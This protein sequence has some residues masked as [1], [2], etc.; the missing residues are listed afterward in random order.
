MK[1]YDT[2]TKEKKDLTPINGKRINLFVCG[3][4]VYD[5]SHIGHAR[6]YI[7]FD[8]LSEYL[9]YKGYVVFYLQNITDIDDKIIKRANESGTVASEI[10]RFYYRAYIEDMLRLRVNGVNFYAPATFYIKEIIDQVKRLID[11]GYAY[12]TEDG[13][14]FDISKFPEYGKLSHQSLETI[15]AG[16]RIEINEK[17]KN[18]ADF[19]LWKKKKPGEPYWDS[20][21]G[22]GRPGWHIEDT[23][24]TE[25]H[26]GPQ[27]DIHGGGSDLIFPHHEC[28]IAQMESVSG[29]KPMVNYWLHTGLLTIKQERMGKSVGN[30]INIREILKDIKPELLRFFLLSSHYRSP[31]DY[32]TESLDLSRQSWEKI[33]I[34]YRKLT[35]IKGKNSTSKYIKDIEKFRT[36]FESAMDDDMNTPLAISVIQSFVSFLNKNYE[37]FSKEEKEKAVSF[38]DD[39]D[40]ILKIIPRD[41]SNVDNIIGILL[42]VRKISKEKKFYEISDY[43]REKL[44]ENGIRVEDTSEGQIWYRI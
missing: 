41:N 9:R 44:N 12:E 10:S 15:K 20:P 33:V 29:K 19:V 18:P 21:W 34:A 16:A 11:K 17:K 1:L 38:F 2:M 36:D 13:I 26:F 4:T 42:D 22:E 24:I 7:F 28:E 40:R 32:S 23:A 30:V 14:Y 35:E 37:S 8:T 25:F 43:I 27:Y 39:I 3:P 31:I 6:T 5:Y